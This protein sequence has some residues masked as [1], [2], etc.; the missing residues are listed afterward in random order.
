M[1]EILTM[2]DDFDE[3]VKDLQKFLGDRYYD[4]I[5]DIEFIPDEVTF[6]KFYTSLNDQELFDLSVFCGK[7]ESKRIY[8][9][10]SP[11]NA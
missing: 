2:I 1:T 7:Q 3:F 9:N 4:H 8:L 6:V 11:N 5:K 10:Y